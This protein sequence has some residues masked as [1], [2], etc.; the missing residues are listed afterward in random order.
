[1]E[2]ITEKKDGFT[3][4]VSGGLCVLV[5]QEVPMHFFNVCGF[6]PKTQKVTVKSPIQELSD[7]KEVIRESLREKVSDYKDEYAEGKAKPQLGRPNRLSKMEKAFASCTTLQA[8]CR[9]TPSVVFKRVLCGCW[10][11]KTSRTSRMA[12]TSLA[13]TS[14]MRKARRRAGAPQTKMHRRTC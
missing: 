9:S 6:F 10:G 11:T 14:A 13:M 1:M 7:V 8:T 12:S 5:G 4:K 3:V 2:D